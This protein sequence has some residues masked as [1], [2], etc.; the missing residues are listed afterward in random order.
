MQS[1]NI[2][3]IF[4]GTPYYV[5]PILEAINRN[6]RIN[7][8]EKGLIAV[9]T[10]PP[11]PAGRGNKLEYSAVDTW[12]HRHDIPIINN[13]E[14]MPAADL[15]VVASY[16]KIIPKSVIEQ[17]KYGILNV[18]PSLLPK[19]R[20][21]SPVQE[22][23]KNGDTI[24]GLTIIK[25]DEKMDHGP[26]VSSFKE[27]ILED[28][29][30]ETLRDR[31]FKKSADFLVELIPSFIKGKIKLKPQNHEEAT[32]T[33]IITKQDGFVEPIQLTKDPERLLSL[34][35][36]MAPWPGVW[37]LIEL[38]GQEKRLKILKAHIEDA[39]LVLDE[40]HLEGKNPV[41]WKQFYEAYPQIAKALS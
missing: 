16:G 22:T 3:I 19:Y 14:D 31:L 35:K 23:L 37:T 7:K 5:I 39:K 20:G 28:D 21:A 15:G 30:T 9:V 26:I 40:V 29:D 2:K 38:N 6:F 41:S 10:Q 33:K 25:M 13:L 4:F 17:F 8:Y 24:T 18:H 32:F 34:I 27:E 11:K 36:A 12:A 1:L